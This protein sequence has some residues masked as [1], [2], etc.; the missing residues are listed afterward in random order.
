LNK[1]GVSASLILALACFQAA[2]ETVHEPMPLPGGLVAGKKVVL[3]VEL[4][5]QEQRWIKSSKLSG[6]EIGEAA[7]ALPAGFDPETPHPIL[8]TCVTGDRHLSN[9]EEMDKYW[10]TAIKEG[11]VVVTG[12]ADPH[13]KRDTKGYR[14]AVTVAAL[15]KL[16]EFIPESTAWPI[17]V[18]GFSGGAKNSALIAA[19]LQQEDYRI[20]GLFMGGCNQDMASRVMRRTSPD[21]KAFSRIPIFLSTGEDDQISTPEDAVNVMNSLKKSGFAH[22]KAETYPGAHRLHT[23]HLP[24]ALGWFEKI[25]QSR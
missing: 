15:R 20:I 8:V 6:Y 18:G 11:W 21:K 7:I 2:A 23:G 12:W 24:E 13:P 25:D 16:A 3:P 4:S 9:I 22:V 17:A 10:P 1:A 14:R 5:R 19:Y